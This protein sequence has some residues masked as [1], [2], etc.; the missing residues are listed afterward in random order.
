[1]ALNLYEDFSGRRRR[2][3]KDN[4]IKG[5]SKCTVIY[6]YPTLDTWGLDLT[7]FAIDTF[8]TGLKV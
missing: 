1:M 3:G 6:K 5:S 2:F 4:C 7:H 8:N